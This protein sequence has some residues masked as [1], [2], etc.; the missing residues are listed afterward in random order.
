MRA[1][2]F[3]AIVVVSCAPALAQEREWT[4]DTGDQ[5]A[6][7]IFGV[8]QT[9]DSGVS[10]WCP[11]GSGEIHIFVPETSAKLKP[12]AAVHIDVAIGDKTFGYEGKAQA[13]E[14]SG[15]PS[16]EAVI[17]AKDA[18]FAALQ[19]ADRFTVTVPG[20]SEVYP[21]AGA[22]FPSLLRTCSK[23]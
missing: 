16:A 17:D 4:F 11:I 23:P 18:V 15:V 3:I 2:K 19:S 8:P 22:D 12:D 7:L 13:N 9:D 6:F 1:L 10:F 21:L 5:D 14:E 20:D